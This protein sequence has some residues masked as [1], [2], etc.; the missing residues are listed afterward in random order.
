MPP[1]VDRSVEYKTRI[2]NARV[3]VLKDGLAG[4][5]SLRY[6]QLVAR[7]TSIAS[8]PNVV[9]NQVSMCSINFSLVLVVLWARPNRVARGF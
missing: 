8:K 2:A 6:T 3:F 9:V 7:L 5:H 4:K 1:E